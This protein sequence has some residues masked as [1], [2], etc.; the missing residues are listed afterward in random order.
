MSIG[1]PSTGLRRTIELPLPWQD[2][3][4][5]AV[6]CHDP[7]GL[8]DGSRFSSDQ[9]ERDATYDAS[10]LRDGTIG[11]GR[12]LDGNQQAAGTQQF[13]DDDDLLALP[14]ATFQHGTQIHWQRPIDWLPTRQCPRWIYPTLQTPR[15]QPTDEDDPAGSLV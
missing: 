11:S 13:R 10:F 14:Q 3:R 7:E 15:E 4:S 1:L 12:R 2:T 8:Q 6:R 9:Q 5:A